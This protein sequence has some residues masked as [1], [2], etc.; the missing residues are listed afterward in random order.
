[1]SSKRM[2]PWYALL[3]LAALLSGCAGPQVS[4]YAAQTPVLDLA[5]YLNGP[6]VAHGIVTDR[7]G[8]VT[9]RFTVDLQGRWVGDDGELDERFRFS[10]GS[11]Q[12]RIW[13]LKKGADGRYSGRADD[14]VGE[15]VGQAAGNALQWRYTLRLPVD[16]RDIEVQFDDWM[17]LID[18]R[19]L[20]NRATISKF[21]IRF[22]E[23]LLAFQRP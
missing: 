2:V 19:T 10:D 13:R 22:G 8:R 1:M 21:G 18:D 5:R 4:D 9:R 6:L 14:V 3:L 12:H 15:A 16:G 7:G 20:I 23:V 11:T 17:F